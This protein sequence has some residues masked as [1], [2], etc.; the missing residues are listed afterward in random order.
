MT[1]CFIDCGNSYIKGV[2]EKP[3][4]IRFRTLWAHLQI[5]AF[6]DL[7]NEHG[8]SK[9]VIATVTKSSFLIELL[10]RLE[11]LN[12]T[13]QVVDKV[14]PQ[15]QPRSVYEQIGKLGVDRWLTLKAV[16]GK[17]KVI[18]IDAGTALTIDWME[19]GEHKGGV[20]VPGFNLSLSALFKNADQ[21][22]MVNDNDFGDVG[23]N[24]NQ[25]INFGVTQMLLALCERHVANFQPQQ[26]YLTG[27]DGHRLVDRLSFALI[28]E[29]DL[30]LTGLKKLEL[31]L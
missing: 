5:D 16:P 18:V 10:T 14:Q 3:A 25:C 20:I 21:L 1:I 13:V 9:I 4:S 27:G 7:L 23:C 15:W 28:W 22:P 19:D 6:I 30:V 24:T 2:I 29:P 12:V 26:V 8:V 11:A 17:D 31:M